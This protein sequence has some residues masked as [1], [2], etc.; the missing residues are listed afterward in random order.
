MSNLGNKETM[1]KNL[2]YYL[3]LNNMSQKDLADIVKVAP[4]TMNDWLRARK[5]PRIDKIEIMANHFGIRKSD[6]VE[7]KENAPTQKDKSIEMAMNLFKQLTPEEKLDI[8]CYASE[9]L[10]K[11]EEH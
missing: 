5:Y 10:N 2:K 9:I 4:S 6:L 3:E 11:R 7:E 1:A 8:I